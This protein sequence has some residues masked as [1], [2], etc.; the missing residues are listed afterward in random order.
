M[1]MNPTAAEIKAIEAQ[2]RSECE[3]DGLYRRSVQNSTP[4]AAMIPFI[5]TFDLLPPGEGLVFVWKHPSPNPGIDAAYVI[6]RPTPA[7]PTAEGA[8]QLWWVQ[9]NMPT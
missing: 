1:D 9:F 5:H 7:V 6:R 3:R 8:A 2:V 4:S